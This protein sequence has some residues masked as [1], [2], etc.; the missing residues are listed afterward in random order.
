VR[1]NT[2]GPSLDRIDSKKRYVIGNVQIVHMECNRIKGRLPEEVVKP[3]IR[4]IM[5]A[6][7]G[8]LSKGAKGK[9]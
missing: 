5:V 9:A 7:Y 8:E 2:L 1:N 4:R 6:C 3:H